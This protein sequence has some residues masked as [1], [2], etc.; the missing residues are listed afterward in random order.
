M[1]LARTI[2][3]TKA[4]LQGTLGGYKIGPGLSVYLFESLGISEDDFTAAVRDLRDD[5]AIAAW[6]RA[7]SDP[8]TYEEINRK[9][10]TRGIRDAAHRAEV[11]TRYESLR[12]RDDLSNWFEILDYDDEVSFSK[13]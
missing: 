4:K 13:P 8:A 2:D 10:R 1:F 11:L 5:E 9:F 12:G 3:K 6:V 7:H